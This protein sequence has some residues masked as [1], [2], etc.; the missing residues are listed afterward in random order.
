MD[1]IFLLGRILLGCIFLMSGLGNF[2]QREGT[3]GYAKSM[4]APS[5]EL[6]VPLTG[7]M[8]ILGAVM[9]ALG[10]FADLGALLL[11]IFLV[12]ITPVMHAYWKDS[13]PQSRQAQQI[14]FN[15]NV[16]LAGAALIVFWLYAEGND[17]PLSI[18]N[19][20]F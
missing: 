7:A 12:A 1:V 18:T 11:L 19:S 8:I 3:I 6:T 15:K 2:R 5:P 17:L 16:S 9:I 13:D 4:G 10:I 14:Q 20:L